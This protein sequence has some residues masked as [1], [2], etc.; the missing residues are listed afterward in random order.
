M[1]PIF[2][3]LVYVIENRLI[4]FIII[5]TRRITGFKNNLNYALFLQFDHFY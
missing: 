5:P 1:A 2:I 3:F 4:I